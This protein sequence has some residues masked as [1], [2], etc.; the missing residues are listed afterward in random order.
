V[1][2]CYRACYGLLGFQ[3]TERLAAWRRRL[4]PRRA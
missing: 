3:T 2:S 1:P 4:H